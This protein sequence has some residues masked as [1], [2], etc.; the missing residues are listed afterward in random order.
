M[1]LKEI[2]LWMKISPSS[3][4]F[5]LFLLVVL[6]CP[7]PS[8]SPNSV[9]FEPSE[10]SVNQSTSKCVSDS[11]FSPDGDRAFLNADLNR[12]CEDKITQAKH[13]SFCNGHITVV[14]DMCCGK[15]ANV[16]QNQGTFL[17]NV[18][19]DSAYPFI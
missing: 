11:N 16:G 19:Q 15:N 2:E 1:I 5:L 9:I 18:L 10:L 13:V 3:S 14:H 6:V 8:A 4:S 7:F 12:W 17:V